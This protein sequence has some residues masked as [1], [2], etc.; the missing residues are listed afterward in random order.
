MKN[1]G[2]EAYK[3]FLLNDALS[4]SVRGVKI[5]PNM[6]TN[7][8]NKFCAVADEARWGQK[9]KNFVDVI[10]KWSPTRLVDAL[11]RFGLVVRDEDLSLGAR[12]VAAV[13]EEGVGDVV[14]AAEEPLVAVVADVQLPGAV[15]G[16]EGVPIRIFKK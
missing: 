11:P 13:V 5:W 4:D 6:R 3:I 10:Y 8:T 15:A 12:P 7:N 1:D 14:R 2:R 9:S 16:A